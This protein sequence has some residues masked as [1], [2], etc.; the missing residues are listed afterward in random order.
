[1]NCLLA[2]LCVRYELSTYQSLFEVWTVHLPVSVWGM[3]CPLTSLCVRYELSTYQSLCE[4]W[5]VYLPVSVWGM[6]CPLTSLCVRYELSTYQPLCEVWTVHLP[7]S[8]CDQ[9]TVGLR[10]DVIFVCFYAFTSHVG[11]QRH[12]GLTIHSLIHH[13]TCSTW[14][15]KVHNRTV[16]C[17]ESIEC[18]SNSKKFWQ[19]INRETQFK[20][21]TRGLRQCRLCQGLNLIQ[22]S[23]PHF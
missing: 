20:V 23:N 8:D 7:A 19:Y 1:M 18:K 14:W 4:V 21:N 5:T 10:L 16:M 3:N 2:S 9:V 17:F 13:Q 12:N 22:D 11:R 15:W 6:N